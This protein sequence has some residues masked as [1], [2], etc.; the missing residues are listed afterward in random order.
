MFSHKKTRVKVLAADVKS[1]ASL[2]LVPYEDERNGFAF[3]RPEEW[4]KVDKY[5]ATVLFEDPTKKSN[6]VGVVVSPVRISSL[7]EFGSPQEVAIKLMEAERKK[8]ST[9]AVELVSIDSRRMLIPGG[10]SATVYEIEYKLDST[11]GM[12]RVYSG[13]TIASRKLFI[14]N[15]AVAEGANDTIDQETESALKCLVSSLRV[16]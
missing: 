8:P 11:R 7:E 5:G 10:A 4:T 15:V 1:P 12:K 2:H 13:V 14:I 9:N 6:S 3:S 16:T